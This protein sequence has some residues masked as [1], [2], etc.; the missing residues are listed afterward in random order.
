MP[1]WVPAARDLFVCVSTGC[2]A[3]SRRQHGSTFLLLA[4]AGAR[5]L[6][7]GLMTNK[8]AERDVSKG[9]RI[10]DEKELKS[11]KACNALNAKGTKAIYM[12]K[13][14]SRFKGRSRHIQQKNSTKENS[15]VLCEPKCIRTHN[16][17]SGK[18]LVKPAQTRST[19]QCVRIHSRIKL[20]IVVFGQRR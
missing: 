11:N 4:T 5:E 7:T 16:T 12:K 19:S 1:F 3:K 15:E 6:A 13:T 2:I 8:Q 18:T 17:S 20:S 9:C 10:A 14:I